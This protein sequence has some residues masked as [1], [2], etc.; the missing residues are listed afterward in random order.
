VYGWERKYH[1]TIAGGI[2]SRLDELQAALL[3]AKLPHLTRWNELRRERAAWYRALLADVPGLIVPEDVEGHVYHLFVVQVT[4]G[5]RDALK[6]ALAERG[7][8]TDVHY[9]LPAHLQPAFDDL[10]YEPGEL[11]VSERLAE[12]V[13]S[14]PC[15]PELT[16]AEVEAVAAAIIDLQMRNGSASA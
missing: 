15:F 8:G 2:N 13:L 16:R 7:I 3:R 6:Q 11:P 14:L 5:R 12:S 4:G 9:P 1:S 10:G